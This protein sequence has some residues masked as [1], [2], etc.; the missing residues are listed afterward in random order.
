MKNKGPKAG[1]IVKSVVPGSIADEMGVE[2]GEILCSVNGSGIGDIF[3]YRFAISSDRLEVLMKDLSGEEY[4]LDIEKDPDEDLGL[5]FE[6][7]LL[8][9]YRSCRNKC[10]FCFIDQMPPGM[11]P[12]LYFKDDD[13][14]LS[15][16]QGNYITLT[17]LSDEDVDRICRYRMEPV[18][19]SIHTTDPDLRC[20]MLNNRFAGSSLKILDRLKEAGIEMNGQIVL[21]R[22][23][24]DGEELDK[25]IE[26]I[27]KWRP[28][29]RSLS[30]VPSGLTKYR[31]GLY[32]L[33]P[34]TADDSAKLIDQIVK[35]QEISLE[36]FG[37]RFVYA[38]D[39]W[40]INA[41]R[42][43]P[44]IENYEDFPQFENGV[45]MIVSMMED[46]KDY[47]DS[48]DPAEVDCSGEYCVSS[49]CG[50]SP[51]PYIKKNVDLI[52]NRFPHIRANVI[53]IENNFF[54]HT[55]N[56]TG[57]ITGNDIIKQL[58]S[59]IEREGREALGEEL[60]IPSCTLRFG[61]DVF[62]DDVHVSDIENELG[63]KVRITGNTG[64]DLVDSYLFHDKEY[65]RNGVE[66]RNS[67]EQ[68]DSSYSGEA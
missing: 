35:W 44:P 41:G 47:L 16:L 65:I 36:R 28:E 9:D 4:I 42:E 26:G 40:Y 57:L 56:V 43:F 63:I 19:I 33:E 24:N 66:I 67:Y 39:E 12:T 29:M 14:R 60:L 59:Y 62:L 46:V 13:S 30:V 61:E 23:I 17:N 6:N 5:E 48:V 64:R 25:T 18:N 32:P 3:D 7:S 11:R 1:H 51:Y 27:M 50:V 21:C 2:A 68:T 20:M 52:M 22:G 34:F 55:I 37:D 58:G 8:D 15:F 53:P 31:E 54:G 10:I 45:G 49:V 38:S